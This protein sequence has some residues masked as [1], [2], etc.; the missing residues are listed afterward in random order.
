MS[1]VWLIDPEATKQSFA[2]A[3]EVARDNDSLGLTFSVGVKPVPTLGIDGE[4][5]TWVFA[6]EGSLYAQ[7]FGSTTTTLGLVDTILKRDN[8]IPKDTKAKL[9]TAFT[10]LQGCLDDLMKDIQ[11]NYV[12]KFGPA[13]QKPNG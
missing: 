10:L 6:G 1:K 5:E 11:R 4:K 13:N 7:L 2:K 8:S 9:S 3:L 12:A